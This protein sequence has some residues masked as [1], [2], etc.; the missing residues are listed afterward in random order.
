MHGV[1]ILF[2]LKGGILVVVGSAFTWIVVFVWS[3]LNMQM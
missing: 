2:F 1:E 3:C